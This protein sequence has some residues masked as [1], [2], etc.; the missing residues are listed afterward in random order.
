LPLSETSTKDKIIAMKRK[1]KGEKEKKFD[2]EIEK[3]SKRKLVIIPGMITQ[4]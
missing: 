2:Q 3:S 4:T 1:K